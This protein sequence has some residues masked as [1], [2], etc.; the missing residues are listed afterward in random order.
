MNPHELSPTAPSRLRVYQF[1]HLGT[2]DSKYYIRKGG[3]ARKGS[4]LIV[5]SPS[6]GRVF[7]FNGR[8]GRIRTPDHWFWRPALWPD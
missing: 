6:E 8:S 7:E 5:G 2:A 3:S 4:R 1:H